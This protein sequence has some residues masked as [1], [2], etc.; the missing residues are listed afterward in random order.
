MHIT[1]LY[2]LF[3]RYREKKQSHS[4][5]SAKLRKIRHWLVELSAMCQDKEDNNRK[6]LDHLGNQIEITGRL[7]S[8][9][10]NSKHSSPRSSA[11]MKKSSSLASWFCDVQAVASWTHAQLT[12]LGARHWQGRELLPPGDLEAV[13]G[14]DVLSTSM[15]E[16]TTLNSAAEEDMK[17]SNDALVMAEAQDSIIKTQ[18]DH[19]NTILSLIDQQQSL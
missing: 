10:L 7:L 8:T 3:S 1:D 2:G 4:V 12:A 18:K 11:V 14:K 13:I 6:I 19:F 17:S 5:A 9:Y 15:S 16:L